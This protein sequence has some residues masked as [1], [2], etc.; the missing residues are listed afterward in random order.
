MKILESKLEKALKWIVAILKKHSVPFQISG[1]FAA[2]IYGS[3]R[4]VNDID[5]DV[6]EKKLQTIVA[7]VEKYITF[8]PGRFQDDKWDLD[9]IVLNYEGQMIDISG[10]YTT[11]IY[12]EKKRKWENY[13]SKFETAHIKNVYGIQVPVMDPKYL[14]EYKKILNGEHQKVDIH[15]VENYIRQRRL[16]G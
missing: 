4:P 5:L 3:K 1:G 9:I 7:D 14:I 6:P 11:K 10:A 15:A 16:I 2:H 12:D 13:P 8:G